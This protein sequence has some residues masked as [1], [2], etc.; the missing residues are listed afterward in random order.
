MIPYL[1]TNSLLNLIL[2]NPSLLLG[3]RSSDSIHETTG[4]AYVD[5]FLAYNVMKICNSHGVNK[6][7]KEA[8][9]NLEN[10]RAKNPMQLWDDPDFGRTTNF[11]NLLDI[12]NLRSK[13]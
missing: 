8:L 5:T 6:D 7:C 12:D 13:T 9:A 1:F 2:K 10:R 11:K 4:Y 3:K